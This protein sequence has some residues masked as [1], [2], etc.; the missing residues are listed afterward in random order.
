MNRLP[1]R[2]YGLAFFT[3][4][5]FGTAAAVSKLLL[6]SMDNLQ[7]LF[8]TTLFATLSLAAI[9]GAQGKLGGLRLLSLRD[10]GV[11]SGL[12][13]IGVFGYHLAY[14]GGLQFLMAQEATI[15]NYLWPLTTML[16][17]VVLLSERW[18]LVKSAAVV[19]SLAGA[20]IVISKGDVFAFSFNSPLGIGL[21]LL[22]ALL[23]GLFSVLAKRTT[24][25]TTL[26]MFVYCASACVLALGSMLAFS[27]FSIPSTSE[28]AGTFWLGGVSI[29]VG[30]WTWFLALRAG[31]TIKIAN[32]AFVSPFLSLVFIFILLGEP[33]HVS[34]VLGL[35]LIVGGIL[36]Q[37]RQK[38]D[39]V[40]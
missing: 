24:Y 33:I 17:A 5:L 34:S 19:L 14:F 22:A 30:F 3:V 21:S 12:G 7:L 39:A 23:Y 32:M 35:G 10:W 15:L 11:L 4:F 31:D 27:S 37:A 26:S 20:W 1:V 29:G 25:D 36:L 6:K 40:A 38:S 28:L 16:F 8:W 18:T 9:A 13:G 2:A